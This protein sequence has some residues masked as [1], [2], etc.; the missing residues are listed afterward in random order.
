M[1]YFVPVPE[2]EIDQ[3]SL[4]EITLNSFNFSM[5]FSAEAKGLLTHR[6]PKIPMNRMDKIYMFLV[7]F[8]SLLSFSFMTAVMGMF[9]EEY[10]GRRFGFYSYFMSNS[11]FFLAIGMTRLL[12]SWSL[13]SQIIMM[14]SIQVL[15]MFVMTNIVFY[16]PGVPEGF[17][18][19]MGCIFIS[20][21]A[22]WHSVLILYRVSY[23]FER[24]GI[25]LIQDGGSVQP[26]LTCSLDL[27]FNLSG[28]STHRTTMYL[29]IICTGM[30]LVS[31]IVHLANART[32]HFKYCEFQNAR[33]KE[34][35]RI[36]EYWSAIKR[37]D[38]PFLRLLIISFVYYLPFPS[39]AYELRPKTMNLIVWVDF[40]NILGNFMNIF[41]R[42]I[43]GFHTVRV[44][45]TYSFLLT[46]AYAVL[47][48]LIFVT[49]SPN[50]TENTAWVMFVLMALASLDYGNACFVQYVKVHH[51]RT[52]PLFCINYGG[53]FGTI[54]A[55]GVAILISE[56]RVDSSKSLA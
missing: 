26:I 33:L 54:L 27:I 22:L 21:A 14:Y 3:D 28:M 24:E 34:K 46:W 44:F 9:K 42:F 47:A 17:W 4:E 2:L 48:V 49:N 31:I 5:D 18:I 43:S 38:I 16:F 35:I 51:E 11:G 1:K 12:R 15:L 25:N 32:D 39:M 37:I 56:F 41:G 52:D 30:A 45:F 10:P 55:S 7:G 23:Y 50:L 36:R 53:T 6:H 40:V 19:I 29:L 13:S 20:G 8:T